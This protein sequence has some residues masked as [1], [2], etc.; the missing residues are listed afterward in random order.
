MYKAKNVYWVSQIAGWFLLSTLIF[1]AS[2]L[3]P[4]SENQEVLI[5]IST[6]CFFLIGIV[7]THI[8]RFCFIK[9]GW[10][11]LRLSFLIPRVLLATVFFSTAMSV[12]NDIAE[13]FLIQKLS[14]WNLGEFFVNVTVMSIFVLLWNGVYFTFHFFQRSSDQEMNNFKLTA[15]HNEIEL[16]NLRS[17]LNPHFL[18]NS[19]NSIRALIEI[20]PVLAKDSIT[21][22][23]NLLR[24]SLANNDQKC[25]LRDEL[26]VINDYVDL[27]KVRFEE[28]VSIIQNHDASLMDFMI[29]PFLLQTLVE[30]AFKHG[31]AKRIK[32]GII[33]LNFWQDNDFVYFSIRNDGIISD[34]IDIGVGIANTRRRLELQYNGKASFELSEMDAKVLALIKIQK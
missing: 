30:N 18:F 19:L 16:K 28:R 15:S 25:T 21:K 32:G 26:S 2:F 34:K 4:K 11:G 9:L 24:K 31:I 10:L 22:L 13:G 17:Q 29:P 8:M 12:L 1:F 27:E 3:S 5:F 20:N 33:E 14:P 7:L 23:A 6:C